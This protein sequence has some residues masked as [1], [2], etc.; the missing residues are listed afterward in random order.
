MTAESTGAAR[1]PRAQRLE[2]IRFEEAVPYDFA[3]AL[4]LARREAVAEGEA[5]NTLYL[6]EHT[7]V[8]TLGRTA[9]PEHLLHGKAELMARGIA[10][11][12]TDRGGGVTYHGPG[13]LV[14]YPV[15]DLRA[16]EPSVGWYLRMLEETVIRLLARYGVAAERS[17]GYTGVWADG[18]KVAAIGVGVHQWVTFHGAAVNVSPRMEHFDF[19][20]PCGI[21]ERP[22]TSLAGLMS[23]PPTLTQTAAD[24]EAAFRECFALP[25]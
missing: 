3:Y 22:V 7:P 19:I 20:V 17:P 8:V 1:A 24:F 21:A 11:H 10:V 4:Q 14:A 18:A 6:L 25:D 15:I 2:V 13:Q 12:E 16:W 9:R 23:R 5:P